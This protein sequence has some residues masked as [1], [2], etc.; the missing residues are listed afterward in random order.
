MRVSDE[1]IATVVAFNI[2]EDTNGLSIKFRAIVQ[3]FLRDGYI[4]N[5]I[6]PG[7]MNDCFPS[8]QI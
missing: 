2:Y 5:L 3:K 6:I 1:R 7:A 8:M 4:V